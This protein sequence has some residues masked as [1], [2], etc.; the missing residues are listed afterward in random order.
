M[1]TI[2]IYLLTRPFN[3]AYVNCMLL[4]ALNIHEIQK[5]TSIGMVSQSALTEYKQIDLGLNQG[6]CLNITY[7]YFGRIGVKTTSHSNMG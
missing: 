7:V 1:L 2:A 3:G 5:R 4:N 6:L